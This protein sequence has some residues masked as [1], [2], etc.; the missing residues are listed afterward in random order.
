MTKSRL[1]TPAVFALLIAVPV[2]ASPPLETETARLLPGGSWRVENVFEAQTSSE[3]KELAVPLGLTVGLGDRL[4]LIVEPVPY[5]SIRPKDGR[6]ASG[7][8]DLEVTVNWLARP[9]TSRLPAFA[10]AGEVKLPT[11]EN[12]LIGTDKPDYTGYL[13]ASRRLGNFDVHANA[14]YTLIGR[15]AGVQTSNVF[16][17]A[18]AVEY[19][20]R[21]RVDIVSEIVGNTAASPEAEQTIDRTPVWGEI[22]G[23]ELVGLVGIRYYVKRDLALSV[24][25]TYDN[26]GAWLVRPGL[27]FRFH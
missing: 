18:A 5:T 1:V 14:G 4:E 21:P 6:R 7:L 22:T 15:P 23:A 11:A 24:G 19:H 13:I 20:V 2:M 25:V 26:N 16:V 8:G 17:Y 12:A 3:G 9:E 27:T 10:L